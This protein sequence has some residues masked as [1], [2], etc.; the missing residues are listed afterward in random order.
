MRIKVAIVLFLVA[1]GIP[2]LFA[3]EVN[4]KK[5]AIY[6][7][8]SI[9]LKYEKLTLAEYSIKNLVGEEV[10]LF[11]IKQDP[12][13]D[14]TFLSFYFVKENVKLESSNVG[15]VSGLGYKSM[16]EKLI[17]WLLKDKVITTDG[18]L[19]PASLQMFVNKYND[20]S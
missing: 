9:F 10:L 11:Q 7:D 13:T 20:R 6:L 18:N 15:R 2:P 8:D 16:L 17:T 12:T 4:V 5:D 1:F 14:K 19:D 3:Q